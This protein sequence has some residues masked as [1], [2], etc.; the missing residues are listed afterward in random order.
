MRARNPKARH[1]YPARDWRVRV[2]DHAVFVAGVMGPL[3]T[4]PQIEKIYRWHEAAG[5]SAISWGSFA[6]FD[7]IWIGYG[8]VHR[9]RAITLAYMLWLVMNSAVALGALIYG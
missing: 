3:M 8:L 4:L 7:I 2:L 5:V 9:D 1:P 6:F